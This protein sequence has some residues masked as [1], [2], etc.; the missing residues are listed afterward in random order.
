M[1][2]QAQKTLP[3][4]SLQ[5]LHNLIGRSTGG[6]TSSSLG[7]DD[8]LRGYDKFEDV[9]NIEVDFL[10]APQSVSTSDATTVVNDLIASAEARKDCVAVASPSR[11]AVVTTGTNAAV[12]ACNNT[13]T[14]ST[15]FVQ[16]NNFLKVYDKYNDKYIKIPAASSTAGLMAATDLV[17]ARW[18]SPAGSRRGR[19][20]G[21][22]DIVLSPTKAERDALYKVGINPIANI[23]AEGVMLFGDKTN[24]F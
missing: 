6:V 21:I 13:Y 19:Y 2:Q 22:T 18:F 5:N 3:H 9:D 16:D 23:P 10:I 4:L 17:A 20:L 24:C 1:P 12:L 11:T 14:K 8:V 7:T 15:Y